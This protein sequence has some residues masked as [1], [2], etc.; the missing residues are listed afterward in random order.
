M[1]ILSPRSVNTTTKSRRLWDSPRLTK[2]SSSSEC[3]GS[4]TVRA[5]GSPKTVLASSNDTPCFLRFCLALFSSHSKAR[6]MGSPSDGLQLSSVAVRGR[7]RRPQL[8]ADLRD[9]GPPLVEERIAANETMNHTVVPA[10]LRRDAGRLEPAGISL[11]FVA[12]HVELGRDQERRGKVAQVG[13]PGWRSMGVP[14]ILGFLDV[15]FPVPG[16]L[17]AAQEETIGE[18]RIRSCV[19]VIVGDGI[20]QNLEVHAWSPTIS[21]HQARHGGKIDPRAVTGNGNS[22]GIA[23]NS[24]ACSAAQRV[25]AYASS[26]AAGNR[27]SGARR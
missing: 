13:R 24:A 27:C 18:S 21:S 17:G 3:N 14:A 20:E 4:G 23:P 7:Q 8:A 16:H 9:G 19:D 1:R 25:A 5:S 15:M 11:C 22:P 6:L 26:A 12:K 10:K 2:R